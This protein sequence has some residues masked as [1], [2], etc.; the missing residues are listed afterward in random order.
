MKRFLTL[1][2]SVVSILL[3]LEG[4]KKEENRVIFEGGTPPVLSASRAA[5]SIPL[6]FLNQDAEA[7]RIS[8]TNPDYRFNT[9]VSSQNVNYQIEIDTAGANFTNPARKTI[10]VSNDLSR[11]FTQGEL[12]D[13]LVNQLA[14]KTGVPHN[15]EMRVKS[16]LSSGAVT[17]IS[18][19]LKF[20][21]TPYVIPPKVAPPPGGR[22]FI[23]GSA[24]PG[25]WG[26]PVPANQELTRV[27]AT[28]YQIT[29][30]LSAGGSYLFLPVNGS[31]DAKY[32]AMGANNSNNP[33]GDDF[34]PG[35]GDM[36]APGAAGTYKIE[37]DFQRGKFTV[38]KV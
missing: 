27:N 23:V 30:P 37:V 16:S 28:T 2:F 14:L 22:L 21:I 33:N 24:T 9:G 5:G 34:K 1:V 19:V 32:G 18:N 29:L 13:Y 6:S 12:N 10:S 4:C 11:S 20:S 25:G 3:S 7:I 31:W 8:W 17:M 35:G 15:I 26:N 36:I 38:T